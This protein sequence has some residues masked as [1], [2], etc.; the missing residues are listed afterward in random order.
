MDVSTSNASG[1]SWRIVHPGEMRAL[2]SQKWRDKKSM[3]KCST[4]LILFIW[5]TQCPYIYRYTCPCQRSRCKKKHEKHAP[6]NQ[7]HCWRGRYLEKKWDGCL[8]SP[9][10]INAINCAIPRSGNVITVWYYY[11]Y[12][13]DPCFFSKVVFTQLLYGCGIPCIDVV[14]NTFV[15]H[16]IAGLTLYGSPTAI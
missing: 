8:S 14:R 11:G 9:A 3:A 7:M 13:D 6:A 5:T 16:R 1:A 12:A 4:Y 15:A 2:F 10:V